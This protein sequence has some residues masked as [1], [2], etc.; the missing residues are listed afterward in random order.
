MVDELT[1]GALIILN[2]MVPYFMCSHSLKI[3]YAKLDLRFKYI[4]I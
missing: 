3:A 1:V 2:I 4:P